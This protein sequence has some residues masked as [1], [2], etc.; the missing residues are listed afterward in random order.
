MPD[1]SANQESSGLWSWV[2]GEVP[3][4]MYGFSLGVLSGVFAN[5]IWH[6][7]QSWIRRSGRT[8]LSVEVTGDRTHVSATFDST[9]TERNVQILNAIKAAT[10]PKA[11]TSYRQP[12][13][14]DAS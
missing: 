10:K 1:S 6:A 14:A 5:W 13:K 3:A 12:P 2:I 7:I 11:K 9:D 8:R 4:F